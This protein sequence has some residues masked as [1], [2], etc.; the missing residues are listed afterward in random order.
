M[1]KKK[2]KRKT[3]KTGAKPPVNVDQELAVLQE[4]LDAGPQEDLGADFRVEVSFGEDRSDTRPFAGTITLWKKTH[5]MG[6]G[7][8]E[9]I[10]FCPRCGAPILPDM[11]EERPTRTP[12]GEIVEVLHGKCID[13]NQFFPITALHAG[14]AV[15]LGINRWAAVIA[16][17]VQLVKLNADIL[18]KRRRNTL[19]KVFD[20]YMK[21]PSARTDQQLMASGTDYELVVYPMERLVADVATGASLQDKI[22]AFLL[23]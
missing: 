15:K 10:Y 1:T 9:L 18:V 2:K 7:S 6:E 19:H 16:D 22:R 4:A 8:E 21:N 11:Y 23:A 20:D 3:A 17:F 14:R 12:S 13:C 5:L